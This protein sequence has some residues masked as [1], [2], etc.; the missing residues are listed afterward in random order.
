[1]T[2]CRDWC[3]QISEFG[4]KHTNR[5]FWMAFSYKTKTQLHYYDR[6]ILQLW[7]WPQHVAST[8]DCAVK[9]ACTTM[10]NDAIECRLSQLSNFRV[11][12]VHSSRIMMIVFLSLS[13]SV[14]AMF[15][16]SVCL[17]F[18]CSV[19]RGCVATNCP[20]IAAA[21]E[22]RCTLLICCVLYE[23][24]IHRFNN[25]TEKTQHKKTAIWI[26]QRTHAK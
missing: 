20:T 3:T 19:S 7:L 12:N 11:R 6:W 17:S 5:D 22:T 4:S 16:Y 2:K 14:V 9:R 26:T 21:T 25:E 10:G 13:L 1:M 23:R 18:C 24:V 8:D 15:P